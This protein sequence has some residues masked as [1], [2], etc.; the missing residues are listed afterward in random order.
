MAVRILQWNANSILI[1]LQE[2]RQCLATNEFDIVCLQETFLKPDK[3][4]S[5]TG[6][7]C[8]RNDRNALK[9]GLAI[10]I[11]DGISYT[12]IPQPSNME[13][14]AVS[15]KTN[16]GYVTLIN[17][18]IPPGNAFTPSSAS[19]D[20]LFSGKNTVIVGDMNAKKSTL[21]QYYRRR[22]RTTPG[23]CCSKSQLCRSQYW[24]RNISN[25]DWLDD[26]H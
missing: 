16:F 26:S 13:T 1:H 19:I 10:L 11:R 17:V 6:Y 4:F 9:G 22:Q 15:F 2:F 23:E 24:T 18:Y 14:Q 20:C 12:E 3:V 5:V 25:Q 21:G 7:T 8:I